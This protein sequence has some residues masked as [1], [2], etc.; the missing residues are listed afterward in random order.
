MD[1]G[2]AGMCAAAGVDRPEK[3][4]PQHVRRAVGRL[5]E[6][7]TSSQALEPGLKPGDPKSISAFATSEMS[8]IFPNGPHSNPSNKRE[9]KRQKYE[10]LL[11]QLLN[12]LGHDNSTAVCF[13]CGKPASV[14]ATKAD[15]PLVDSAGRR[16]FHPALNLGHQICTQ[17]ALAVQFLPLS[18]VR[19]SP[20][21]LFWFISTLDTDV[22]T[23]AASKLNL[24][25]MDKMIAGNQRLRFY[26]DWI[27]PGRASSVL[28]AVEHITAH[29]V[30]AGLADTPQYPVRAVFFSNDN[31]GGNFSVVDIPD[32]VFRFYSRLRI[33]HNMLSKF[34][35]EATHVP[36]LGER[37]A[38]QIL[39]GKAIIRYCVRWNESELPELRGGWYAHALYMKEVLGVRDVYIDTIE[40]I[41]AAIAESD[42][43]IAE[44]KSLRLLG[45]DPMR[46]YLA[47]VRK[48]YMNRREFYGLV[49]PNDYRAASRT[50]DYIE[51]A[52]ADA[53]RSKANGEA[54][55]RWTEDISAIDT[56][57]H[58][59]IALIERVG[60]QVI[61]SE[62]Q[63]EKLL[64]YL[65]LARSES[66]VRRAW[67]RVLDSGAIRWT[68]FVGLVPPDGKW[69]WLQ[70]R[71]Y[72][73]AYLI[74]TLRG[75]AKLNAIDEVEPVQVEAEAEYEED[76]EWPTL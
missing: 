53:V 72:M 71:D 73:L 46:W 3:L 67:L 22:S 54:F 8:A 52:S 62:Y 40:R 6:L 20:G 75:N 14:L 15:F 25:L 70:I 44:L 21:G 39:A 23:Y 33:T 74:D 5:I 45:R 11:L 26:G 7:M 24:P 4:D 68:D 64:K 58:P 10:A 61:N 47:A 13:L 66:D 9:A 31:R 30:E 49:P 12:A 48:G 55:V 28:G 41:A 60:Q 1:A 29:R 32:P 42:D 65:K 18:L 34:T 17:C 43:P 57:V 19:T 2:I 63:P 27:Q 56:D 51:G 69:K 35:N 59:M 37:L 16:N 38:Q 50:L 36:K 76:D